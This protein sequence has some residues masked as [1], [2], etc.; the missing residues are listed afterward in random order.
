MN[1]II[2]TFALSLL[3]LTHATLREDPTYRT[4]LR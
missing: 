2:L 1:V 3:G 4:L